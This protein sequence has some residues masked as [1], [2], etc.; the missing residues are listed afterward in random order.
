MNK[1]LM[2]AAA[3]M[4]LS[5][6]A[7]AQDSNSAHQHGDKPAVEAT[8]D[9]ATTCMA[10]HEGMENCPADMKEKM[11]EGH[12]MNHTGDHHMRDD[13]ADS[14]GM[15]MMKDGEITTHGEGHKMHGEKAGAMMDHGEMNADDCKAKHEAMGHDPADHCVMMP[16]GEEAPATE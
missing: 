16:A 14:S 1:I 3:I 7:F 10:G 4:V 6:V 5:P 15:G 8:V 2:T 12:M 11:A 9:D 13:T